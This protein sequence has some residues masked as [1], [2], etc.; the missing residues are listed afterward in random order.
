MDSY[1]ERYKAEYEKVKDIRHWSDS[2]VD[3]CFYDGKETEY[4]KTYI[5][6][7]IRFEYYYAFNN[8][9][10]KKEFSFKGKVFKIRYYD[11]KGDITKVEKT[12]Y[13]KPEYESLDCLHLPFDSADL[14]YLS[15]GKSYHSK[16]SFEIEYKKME[17]ENEE[18]KRYF[19]KQEK[20]Q[21]PYW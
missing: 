18:E 2:Y 13:Y 14:M 7:S 15:V 4:I 10:F 21:E 20:A 19:E 1:L 6:G 17:K 3:H 5:D 16:E 8:I 12:E 11:D 9:L